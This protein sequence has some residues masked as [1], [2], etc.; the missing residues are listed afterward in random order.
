MDSTDAGML[1][2]TWL[3]HAERFLGTAEFAGVRDNPQIMQLYRDVGHGEVLHDEIAWCAAF[4]GSCLE[5]SGIRSTRSLMAR[6][7]LRWGVALPAPRPGCIAVL[8]R[9]TDPAAGH[10][11]FFIRR[12]AGKIL[13][14]GGNQGDR[15]EISAFPQANLLGYRW[16]EPDGTQM[17][18]GDASGFPSAL[19]HV[20]ASE[21]GWSNDRHDAGGPTNHGITLAAYAAWKGQRLTPASRSRLVAELRAIPMASVEAIYRDGYWKAARCPQLPASVALM[22]FDTAVN[23][24]PHSAIVILQE[25]LGVAVDGEIGPRTLAAAFTADA[26]AVIRTY[27]DIRRRRY[28][29]MRNFARFGRG[30]LKRVERTEAAARALAG[31]ARDGA[32]GSPTKSTTRKDA[33]PMQTEPKWWGQSMTIWGAL[34]TALSTVLPLIGPFIGLDISAAM[35]KELGEQVVVVLQAIGGLVGTVMTI[36]GRMRA[37]APLA[38]RPMTLNI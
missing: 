14:L 35:I 20:L 37:V 33:Q 11:G 21:G 36:Y 34:L 7:Y 4:L 12:T 9:G 27:A 10:C 8:R 23:Q 29:T 32:T 18:T 26:L 17:Q 31:Q 19:R 30:W 3:R 2:P 13:L 22:Q 16:P 24:G 6:S 28:R 5:R 1:K 38:S 15:V 25:A